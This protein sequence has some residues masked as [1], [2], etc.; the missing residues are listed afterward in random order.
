M[1]RQPGHMTVEALERRLKA[2]RD[3]PP[4]GVRRALREAAGLSLADVADAVG[5]SRQAVGHWED[6]T[7]FPRPEHLEPYV[8]VLRLLSGGPDAAA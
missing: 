7:R 1:V 5:V 3:L 8:Q 4:P 6:G 2:A